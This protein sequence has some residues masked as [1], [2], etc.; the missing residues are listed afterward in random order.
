MANQRVDRRLEMTS[1]YLTSAR[2]NVT[3]NATCARNQRY[4]HYLVFILDQITLYVMTLRDSVFCRTKP[5]FEMVRQTGW[6]YVNF[7]ESWAHCRIKGNPLSSGIVWKCARTD[8]FCD[9]NVFRASI[10]IELQLVFYCVC[11]H[12]KNYF[13]QTF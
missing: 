13:N 7:C 6:R 5:S 2:K 9:P 11:Y 12:S 3:S 4:A 10:R 1:D 8:V